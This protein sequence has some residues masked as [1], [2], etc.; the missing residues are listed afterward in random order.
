MLPNAPYFLLALSDFFYL[1]K[2]AASIVEAQP[3]YKIEARE[4]LSSYIDE[5]T[6]PLNDISGYGLELLVA[7]WLEGFVNSELT[8]DTADPSL[9]WLFDSGLYEA[10]KNGSVAVEASV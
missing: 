9:R 5:S 6:Q 10:I 3:D 8:K 1:W 7:S 4:A 2:D